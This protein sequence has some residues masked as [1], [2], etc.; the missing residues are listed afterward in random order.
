[1]KT[2]QQFLTEAPVIAP[3][4]LTALSRA[5]EDVLDSLLTLKKTSPDIAGFVNRFEYLRRE[6]MNSLPPAAFDSM[7]VDLF[8]KRAETLLR[9]LRGVT[10]AEYAPPDMMKTYHGKLAAIKH[11]IDAA[12]QNLT[13]MSKL[14]SMPKVEPAKVKVKSALPP[15]D[16]A[17]SALF[18]KHGVQDPATL[19]P[20]DIHGIASLL[21]DDNYAK[22]APSREE[23]V[24][25]LIGIGIDHTDVSM[26][27]TG[28]DTFIASLTRALPRFKAPRKAGRPRKK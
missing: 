15:L 6:I 5:Y 18:K 8:K 21:W 1:M 9:V 26:L 14:P 22:R 7:A 4:W 25:L 28:R 17:I 3:K 2:F 19:H 20:A 27:K 12:G 23:V 24:G 13:R 11:E 16:K 10:A